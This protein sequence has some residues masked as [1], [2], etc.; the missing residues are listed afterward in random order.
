VHFVFKIF[1]MVAISKWLPICSFLK[2]PHKNDH[3]RVLAEQK[4]MRLDRNNI[5]I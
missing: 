5:H 1:K 2:K 4:L 3:S